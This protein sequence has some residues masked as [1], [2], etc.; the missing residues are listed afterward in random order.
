MP[1]GL[2]RDAFSDGWMDGV[3]TEADHEETEPEL[4][5]VRV[6]YG[7]FTNIQFYWMRMGKCGRRMPWL[8]SAFG[9]NTKRLCCPRLEILRCTLD[10]VEV[11]PR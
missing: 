9:E 10:K 8:P 7:V 1:T 6:A 2:H 4:N 11:N 3:A 5:D